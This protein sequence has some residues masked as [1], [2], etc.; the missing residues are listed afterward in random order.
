VAVGLEMRVVVG[1]GMVVE[2][3]HAVV[4]ASTIYYIPYATLSPTKAYKYNRKS[5]ITLIASHIYQQTINL[6][7]VKLLIACC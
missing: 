5:V 7:I 4:C 2:A 6:C 1:V 3:V